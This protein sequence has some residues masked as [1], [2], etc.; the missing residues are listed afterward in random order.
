MCGAYSME[1]RISMCGCDC[2][3]QSGTPA[4]LMHIF[5]I[6]THARGQKTTF[7][8]VWRYENGEKTVRNG[9]NIDK[10]DKYC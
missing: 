7:Q 5:K 4:S 9:Y 8:F 10:S 2:R 6:D 3:A 1:T